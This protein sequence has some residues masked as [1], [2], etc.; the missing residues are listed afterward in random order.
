LNGIHLYSDVIT[1]TLANNL[2]I[3]PK[4]SKYITKLNNNV[5]TIEYNN[6]FSVDTTIID[7]DF[8]LIS[9]SY[10]IDAGALVENFGITTDFYGASRLQGSSVDIGATEY[11][12]IL[13]TCCGKP[14][15]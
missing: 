3:N 11:K 14:L 5:K 10:P 7:S 4:N 8:R 1:T 2:I 9:K 12:R 6:L 13:C 15:E